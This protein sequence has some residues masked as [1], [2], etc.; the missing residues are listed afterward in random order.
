MAYTP[1]Y[2]ADDAAPI[3]FDTGAKIVLGV[4]AFATL[5]GLSIAVGYLMKKWKFKG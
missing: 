2:T 1:N 5:I 4:A 3:I